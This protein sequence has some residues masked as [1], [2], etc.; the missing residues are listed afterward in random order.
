METQDALDDIASK[1]PSRSANLATLTALIGSTQGTFLLDVLCFEG[2][3]V[4]KSANCQRPI[5]AKHV[6]LGNALFG[7]KMGQ[8]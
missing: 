2:Q 8:G 1:G 5:H 6:Q 4:V 3:Q 7:S